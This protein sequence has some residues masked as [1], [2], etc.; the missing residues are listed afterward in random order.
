MKNSFLLLFALMLTTGFSVKAQTKQ[1]AIAKTMNERFE[2]ADADFQKLLAAS[3]TDGELFFY[4][5]DN[6]LYWGE[7]ELAEKM[8]KRGSE[9]APHS[10]LNHSGLGRIAW[11]KGDAAGAQTH[12]SK[13]TELMTVKGS[14]V[15]KGTQELTYLKMAECYTQ[16]EKKNLDQAFAFL[17]A[18]M[19]L[20]KNKRGE[21][22]ITN[23]EL[24]VQLGDYYAEKDGFN[25]SN[26]LMQYSKA[27]EISPKYTRTLL[28]E[29]QLYVK[30]KN[31]DEGLKY[32][33]QAIE[34]DPSFAPAYRDKAELLYKAGRYPQAIDSYAKYLELNNNC[35]VQQRYASFVFLTKDYKKAIE[36]LE[37]AKP[38]NLENAFMYRLLGYSYFE[39]GDFTKGLENMNQFFAIAES[40]GKPTIIGNDYAYKGKLLAKSGQDSLGIEQIKMAMTK[41]TA[42]HDGYGDIASIYFKSKNYTKAAEYYSLKVKSTSTPSPLDFYYLG[43][44]QYFSKDYAGADASFA[45]AASKYPDA[46]FWRGRCNS[47]LDNQEL[48]TGMAKPYFEAFITKVGTDP[49]NIE[50]NKKTLVETYSYLGFFYYTQKNFECSKAAWLKVQELDAANEKA[51][52]ALTDKDLMVAVGT[53]ALVPVP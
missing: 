27:L 1:E 2:S 19:N 13:A 12:F 42:Y 32:F 24:Y 20:S 6:Y 18:A 17:N 21:L 34:I 45:N 50:T 7:M 11:L 26:A 43:Q 8:F 14:T 28:R 31:W 35:R 15:E 25:L 48:P 10:P 30:V 44:A 4:A 52:I 37:K 47:R 3:P 53:C 51:K 41:D 38:C 23:P 5:G 16:N 36:E 46:N 40:K 22:L 29:G 49:K 9:V 33:N 39:T